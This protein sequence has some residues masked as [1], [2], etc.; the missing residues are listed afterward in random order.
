LQ[1]EVA[2]VRESIIEGYLDAVDGRTVKIEG[3]LRSLLNSTDL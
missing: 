3:D 1:I 2:R